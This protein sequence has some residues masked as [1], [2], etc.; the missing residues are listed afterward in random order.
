MIASLV[1]IIIPCKD[2]F[3]K[4]K[5]SIENIAKQTRISGTRILIL[6]LGSEDGSIQY[7][8][9]ASLDFSRLLNIESLRIT[10]ENKTSFYSEIETPYV[11]WIKPGTILDS[12][13]FIFNSINSAKNSKNMYIHTYKENIIK[14][15]FPLY[16]LKNEK[17]SL[18]CI[19]CKR[20]LMSNIKYDKGNTAINMKEL[21]KNY[22]IINGGISEYNG[23]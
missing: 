10:D 11:L 20:G 12:K 4:I 19:F 16:Y 14:R 9:Q 8:A 3:Y 22:E 15:I 7:A 2:S 1:T 17:I 21:R 13:D 5:A 18:S 6:D 23:R